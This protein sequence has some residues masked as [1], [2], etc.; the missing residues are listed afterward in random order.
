M[1]ACTHRAKGSFL[2]HALRALFRL[3]G[4]EMPICLLLLLVALVG[5][6]SSLHMNAN[7][8][9]GRAVDLGSGSDNWQKYLNLSEENDS[10]ALVPTPTSSYWSALRQFQ[11]IEAD[12][13]C[14]YTSI[15]KVNG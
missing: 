14:I 1:R 7:F 4:L 6:C 3:F 11:N 13:I 8:A 9:G 15:I 5:G 12:L 10:A 2:L